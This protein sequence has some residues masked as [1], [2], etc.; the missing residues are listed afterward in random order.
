LISPRAVER[1]AADWILLGLLAAL[2]ATISAFALDIFPYPFGI[3]VLT[4]LLLG[5]LLARSGRPG[6][7]SG[8]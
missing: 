2:V 4:I 7:R 8:S 1:G 5:R 6:P 3:L